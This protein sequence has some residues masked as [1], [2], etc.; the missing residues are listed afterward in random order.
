MLNVY[1]RKHVLLVGLLGFFSGLPLALTSSTLTAWLFDSGVERTAIGL[2]A[3]VATPYAF[4][5]IWSPLM[6]GLRLPVMWRLGKRRSWILL[7]QIALVCAMA[8]MRL[9][10]QRFQLW[11]LLL[12][13]L[14]FP[15]P[16]PAK[17]S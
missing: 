4:K 16:V 14:F 5:F 1:T 7:T 13:R 8:A 2:F 11:P 9:P 3:A 12:L 15:A 10:T 17:I 6:D